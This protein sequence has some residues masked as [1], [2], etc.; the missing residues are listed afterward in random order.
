MPKRSGPSD[1]QKAA[2]RGR[3]AAAETLRLRNAAADA[4]PI[5]NPSPASFTGSSSSAVSSSAVAPADDLLPTAAAAPAAPDGATPAEPRPGQKRKASSSP[6]VCLKLLAR[7]RYCFGSHAPMRTAVPQTA[8]RGRLPI[9]ASAAEQVRPWPLSVLDMCPASPPRPCV[10]M[11]AAPSY[12]ACT[13]DRL[14]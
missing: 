7:A 8:L 9:S 1:S 2:K 6:D 4:A 11:H 12:G 10:H 13:L 14:I 5:A 3:E